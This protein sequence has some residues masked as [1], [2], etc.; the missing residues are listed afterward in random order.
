LLHKVEVSACKDPTFTT[1]GPPPPIQA[2]HHF[3][4]HAHNLDATVSFYTEVL[5]FERIP[6]YD[7]RTPEPESKLF[8][9][10]LKHPGLPLL[11]IRHDKAKAA[12]QTGWDPI[13]FQI[14]GEKE[15]EEW[16]A[17]L[18]EK[19]VKRSNVLKGFIGWTLCFEDPEKRI[20]RFY[21]K[22]EH[23]WTTDVDKDEYWL[24][25]N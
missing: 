19:K 20:I 10:L 16:A 6:E 14:E 5:S 18:D 22:E 25:S 9:V 7:H 21:T 17:W 24:G 2:V 8:A 3:K 4:F 11:E 13:I 12:K 1:M 15:M 23:D